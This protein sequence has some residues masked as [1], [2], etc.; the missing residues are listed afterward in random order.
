MNFLATRK[1]SLNARTSWTWPTGSLEWDAM[2]IRDPSIRRKK[3]CLEEEVARWRAER[4]VWVI[5]AREGW[6]DGI[7]SMVY[8]MCYL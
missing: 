5:S 4:A 8:D 7:R 2:S 1:A 6:R 3:P